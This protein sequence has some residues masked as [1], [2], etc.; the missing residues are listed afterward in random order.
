[1]RPHAVFPADIGVHC[2]DEELCMFL[3]KLVCES[4]L[5]KN[6]I[7]GVNPYQYLPSN[8]PPG[9][10]WYL[11]RSNESKDT[12]L[13]YWKPTEEASKI[14][15]NSIITGWRTTFE[16][17]EGRASHEHKTNWLMQ[18][19]RITYQKVSENSKKKEANLLCRV[20]SVGAEPKSNLVNPDKIVTSDIAKRCPEAVVP[21]AEKH[22][23][24]ASTS[25]PQVIKDNETGTLTV[26]ERLPDHQVE[27]MPEIEIDFPFGDDYIEL[28]DLDRPASFSSSS[29]SSCLTMSS[30]ECFDSLALLEELEPKTSQEQVNTKANCK[31]SIAVPQKPDELVLYAAA[32]SSG[33]LNKSPNEEKAKSRSSNISNSVVCV[34]SKENTTKK[35]SRNQK[36]DPRNEDFSNSHTTTPQGGKKST[37]V[38][39]KKLKKSYLCFLPC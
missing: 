20:Q 24:Y 3:Q 34:K 19:Y 38:K 33:S 29:N 25:K 39:P 9:Y 6:V 11:I 8:L 5:P 22:A 7:N 2:T 15:S 16:F 27:I 32:S 26:T 4:L 30:D 28:L 23:G 36:P 17:F 18:E 35:L 13:G 1:M 37:V 21:L 12:N 14:F 31:L 10:F